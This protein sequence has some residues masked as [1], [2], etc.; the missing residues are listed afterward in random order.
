M[1]FPL[2][3]F[4]II[5]LLF[6]FKISPI[7]A[8]TPIAAGTNQFPNGV[9]VD[10]DQVSIIDPANM[11]VLGRDTTDA[12]GEWHI[13]SLLTAIN[14]NGFS[15]T[16]Q[17]FELYPAF[18]NPG[19][20]HNL[21]FKTEKP[22]LITL[23]IYDV[24][25]RRVQTLLHEQKSPNLYLTQWDGRDRQGF[26]V[27]EGIYF[28]V[29]NNYC[30]INYRVVNDDSLPIR[31]V[32][33]PNGDTLAIPKKGTQ[34]VQTGYNNLHGE[35]TITS[36]NDILSMRVV[37][38]GLTG[39]VNEASRRREILQGYGPSSDIDDPS[40]PSINFSFYNINYFDVRPSKWDRR[41]AMRIHQEMGKGFYFF[42]T[43]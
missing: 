29:L 27:A 22:Y 19:K 23:E 2:L 43:Q 4:W 31:L 5:T 40:H 36:S 35:H 26:D 32:S 24:L 30:D 3:T 15:I 33:L 39:V 6:S 18:P 16:P 41:K 10:N 13:D 12:N 7:N 1:K 21:I 25:G 28:A 42:P 11:Q 17:S 8:Q 37:L 38:H 14:N 9:P 34:I 20:T